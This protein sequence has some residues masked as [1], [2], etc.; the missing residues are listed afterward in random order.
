M[1]QLEPT[2]NDNTGM[3]SQTFHILY[4]FLANGID[5]RVIG[6]ILWCTSEIHSYYSDE[7]LT[8]PH[9]NIKS[10]Q[11]ITSSHLHLAFGS[12]RKIGTHAQALMEPISQNN[13]QWFRTSL[14][15]TDVV[16][17]IMFVNP[18]TPDPNHVLISVDDEFQPGLITNI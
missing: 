4:S 16:K 12:G 9:P 7:W 18:S 6:G 3:M 15:I 13:D 8:C 5:K 17:M 11:T 2:K 10:C 14:T 1:I